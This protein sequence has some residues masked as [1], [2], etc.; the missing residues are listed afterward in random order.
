[1]QS[2]ASILEGVTLKPIIFSSAVFFVEFWF[3]KTTDPGSTIT[4]EIHAPKHWSASYFQEM[5]EKI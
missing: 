2:P 5:L 1:M 4:V 3:E